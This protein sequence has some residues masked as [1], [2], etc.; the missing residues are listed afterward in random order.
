MKGRGHTAR[1]RIIRVIPWN[2]NRLGEIELRI[3][4]GDTTFRYTDQEEGEEHAHL[5]AGS[6]LAP[7]RCAVQRVCSFCPKYFPGGCIT[8][9]TSCAD[10]L[11]DSSPSIMHQN[12]SADVQYID[13]ALYA[14]T[15][16]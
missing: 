10:V 3:R 1:I 12:T 15:T 14:G 13:L 16:E 7:S 2:Q 9:A 6:M 11:Q 4:L 5:D 8:F